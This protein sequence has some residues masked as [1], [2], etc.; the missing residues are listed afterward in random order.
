MN[1]TFIQPFL[2]YT[3][4]TATTIGINTESTYDWT[5]RKWTIPINLSIS[6]LVKFGEQPVSI[7]LGGRYYADGP[8]GGPD[9]GLRLNFTLLFPEHHE[10]PKSPSSK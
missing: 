8:K 1:S 5:A 7:Q 10:A 3:W 9:W 2:S 6:Q 4:P